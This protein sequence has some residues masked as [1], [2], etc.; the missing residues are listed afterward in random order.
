MKT[1]KN[2]KFDLVSTLTTINVIKIQEN[3]WKIIENGKVDNTKTDDEVIEMIERLTN[4]K[5]EVVVP[6]LNY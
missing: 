3:C 1:L 2:E 5:F 6:K 4:D